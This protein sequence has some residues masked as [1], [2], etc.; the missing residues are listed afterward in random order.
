MSAPIH[1]YTQLS[2]FTCAT[3]THSFRKSEQV[4]KQGL[5]EKKKL[6]DVLWSWLRWIM[7]SLV[8]QD[9]S[10]VSP[11]FHS[12]RENILLG[13][14]VDPW[15]ELTFEIWRNRF[16]RNLKSS[17]ITHR[18]EIKAR[19]IMCIPSLRENARNVI[20]DVVWANSSTTIGIRVSYSA[21]HSIDCLRSSFLDRAIRVRSNKVHKENAWHLT[22]GAHTEKRGVSDYCPMRTN[23]IQSNACRAVRANICE[24]GNA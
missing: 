21:D 14:L 24:S 17:S 3:Q 1:P 22:I 11:F 23:Y 7:S 10:V 6:L 5:N 19:T 9:T 2:G 18:S 4:F 8:A 12:R 16:Q 20:G 13:Q 15:S